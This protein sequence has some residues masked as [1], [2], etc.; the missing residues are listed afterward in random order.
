MRLGGIAVVSL[1]LGAVITATSAQKKPTGA[2]A[3]PQP[4]CPPDASASV[5]LPCD[6]PFLAHASV[7]E[8]LVP[9]RGQELPSDGPL[10]DILSDERS[11]RSDNDGLLEAT[12]RIMAGTPDNPVRVG[13]KPYNVITYQ[14]QDRLG[15]I[16]Y[17][18]NGIHPGPSLITE[19]GDTINL[20]VEDRRTPDAELQASPETFDPTNPVPE[21]T[22]L[23]THGLLVSPRGN[24][25]NIYRAFLPGNT[26]T[27]RIEI[28]KDHDRGINWYHPHVHESTAPQ[29]FGGLAGILK[30]GDMAD[31]PHR[32]GL[33]GYEQKTMVLSAM[34]LAKS[35]KHPG[36]YVIG[37]SS[38][39]TNP[40]LDDPNPN[41]VIT[42][43]TDPDYKPAFPDYRPAFFVNGQINP[44]IEM[45]PGETE[46]WTIT[47]VNAFANYSLGIFKIGDDGKID[48]GAPLFRSVLVAQDGNDHVTPVEALFTR[49]RDPLQDTYLGPG[50]R[51]SWALT[52]PSEPGDYYLVNMTDHAITKNVPNLPDMLT[53]DPIYSFVPSMIMA[54]VR[55]EGQPAEKP[56]PNTD[57]VAPADRISEDPVLTREIAFDFDE[58][59]LTGRINF[60]YFP[61][62]GMVQ[63]FSGDVERWVLSTY[64]QDAHP[65]HI[66]QGQFIIEKI[67]YYEDQALT[68]LRTDLPENPIVNRFPREM[69]TFS[70]PGRS[71]VY[72]KLRASE[73]VGKFVMHCHL[74]R[75]EDEGMMISVRVLP[76]RTEVISAIGAGP[77]SRPT[78]SL[79]QGATGKLIAEFEAYDHNYRGGVSADAGSVLSA[80][81]AYIA[82]APNTGKPQI[83]LFDREKLG[84]PIM[85]FTPFGGVGDGAT[86]ALGDV[87]G[88][89]IDEIII[90]SGRGTKPS[91]AVYDVIKKDDGSLE[92]WLLLEVP[93]LDESYS[94]AGVRVASGDIDGDNWDD[95]VVAN[96]PGAPNR[97]MV[98]GGQMLSEAALT[99]DEFGVS[100]GDPN[101]DRDLKLSICQATSTDSVLVDSKGIIAGSD[102]LNIS[103]G[104]LGGGFATYPPL[105]RVGLNP[106]VPDVYRA[107]I[108]ATRAT[109]VT[110]P[111]VFLFRYDGPGGHTHLSDSDQTPTLLPVAVYS[112][113][114]G[115]T[116][117]LGGLSLATTLTT[118]ADKDTPLVG[119]V[120][121]RGPRSQN[122]SYFSKQGAF[123]TSPWATK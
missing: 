57:F 24:G 78:V 99:Q 38:N 44:I 65:L 114:P 11:F 27:T 122:I 7:G 118:V 77:D 3:L 90:G 68:K 97:I 54:T 123:E 92:S 47:N 121:A 104:V 13:S 30:I 52:A 42:A 28:P 55:V 73:F 16:A 15:G 84:R 100:T 85:E 49:Q 6:E 71:K 60:G 117:P 19:P 113:F 96:G 120:A 116:S 33:V 70:M 101:L 94:E 102:G 107:L 25:D 2:D 21:A 119:L 29:V 83:R 45:Q 62:N 32:V 82:T 43:L 76:P 4:I 103:S 17:S 51:I 34:S 98:L 111:E 72:F 74:L 12:F 109:A 93:V 67:E 63:S 58:E 108:A 22:N 48:P 37:P 69:D 59:L 39:G 26:Y 115:E 14:D 20:T 18:Y 88:D 41:V 9:Y 87:D 40:T 79:V 66:H 50:Q 35:E 31:S 89:A 106:P 64:S 46:V 112:P 105:T 80:H 56:V 110:D 36:M 86:V 53:F 1:V 61:N 5:F 10:L 91:V 8:A 81:R 95:I 23:H 75:H